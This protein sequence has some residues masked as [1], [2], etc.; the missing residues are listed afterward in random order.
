MNTVR[1]RYALGTFCVAAVVIAM[2]TQQWIEG[3]RK[4]EAARHTDWIVR[5]WTDVMKTYN[6][7]PIYPPTE[8]IHVG[9]I[10]GVSNDFDE[11]THEYRDGGLFTTAK[12]AY[13]PMTKQLNEY[14]HVMPVFPE[15]AP[16][17]A[18]SSAVWRQLP[19]GSECDEASCVRP[20]G[21]ARGIFEPPEK[22][23]RLSIVALPG[24]SVNRSVFSELDAGIVAGLMNIVFG[25]RA[26]SD[27]VMSIKVHGAE[28]Y[29]VPA[30]DALIELKKFCLPAR[31]SSLKCYNSNV[32]AALGSPTGAA[33]TSTSLAIVYRLYVTRSIEYT[34]G[35]SSVIGAQAKALLKL[36]EQAEQA[37]PA[38][39]APCPEGATCPAAAAEATSRSTGSSLDSSRA[40]LTRSLNAQTAARTFPGGT[41]TVGAISESGVSIIETFER[42]VAIGYRSVVIPTI[43]K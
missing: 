25:N 12:M 15:T 35:S 21:A 26:T 23:D 37:T 11:K 33:P 42:P 36:Q 14:Y 10:F 38:T 3:R 39:S 4:W 29:G 22:F 6:M 13:V 30:M 5:Q 41:L 34:F 28:T 43:E 9:D 7:N 20:S 27:D 2:L 32:A 18:S 31:T 16:L 40:A 17:P 1:V 8:D 19:A 24:F